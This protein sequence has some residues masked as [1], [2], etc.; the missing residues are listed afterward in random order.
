[1]KKQTFTIDDWGEFIHMK[2][3]DWAIIK[4][5]LAEAGV[6]VGEQVIKRKPC[7]PRET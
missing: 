7:K 3:S 2:K 1:M 6:K 4:K 5:W